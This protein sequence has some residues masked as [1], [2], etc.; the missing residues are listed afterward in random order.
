MALR[1]RG[2]P[3]RTLRGG[4]WPGCCAE[5]GSRSRVLRVYLYVLRGVRERLPSSQMGD[6]WRCPATPQGLLRA[7]ALR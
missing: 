2:G 5:L 4:C 7:A 3:L 1:P 6:L